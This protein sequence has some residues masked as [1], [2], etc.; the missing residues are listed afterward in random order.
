[1]IKVMFVDDRPE[2]VLNQWQIAIDQMPAN[3]FEFYLL[4]VEIFDTEEKTLELAFLHKPDL[5]FVGFGLSSTI[6]TGAG[7]IKLLRKH[8]FDGLIVANSG[9]SIDQFVREGVIPSGSINRSSEKLR[10]CL[11]NYIIFQADSKA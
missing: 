2:E 3:S 10:D 1:V 7:I 8:E 5:I 9:G 6:S 4:P 11:D